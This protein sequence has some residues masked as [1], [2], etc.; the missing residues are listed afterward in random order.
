MLWFFVGRRA[1]TVALHANVAWPSA[2]NFASTLPILDRIFGTSAPA[3]E[4]L[5]HSSAHRAGSL[6]RRASMTAAGVAAR[7]HA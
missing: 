7:W 3:Q 2:A 5:G 4:R 6:Q 1:W